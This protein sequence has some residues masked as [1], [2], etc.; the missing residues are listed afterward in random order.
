MRRILPA[1][2]AFALA[3][4]APA[5]SDLGKRARGILVERQDASGKVFPEHRFG[6][7]QQLGVALSSRKDL[8]SK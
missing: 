4:P 8:D 5:G 7:G 1:L 6:L 2:L 3:L